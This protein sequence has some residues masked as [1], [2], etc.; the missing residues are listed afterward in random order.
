MIISMYDSPPAQ[1]RCRFTLG[2]DT[3]VVRSRLLAAAVAAVALTVPLAAGC[4]AHSVGTTG[5]SSD[6]ISTAKPL[7]LTALIAHP[8]PAVVTYPVGTA[9]P[10]QPSSSASPS[11]IPAGVASL[12]DIEAALEKTLP[13]GQAVGGFAAL[14]VH[15][16]L[17]A[18][19]TI[20]ATGRGDASWLCS[21]TPGEHLTKLA[22]P[23]LLS[24]DQGLHKLDIREEIEVSVPQLYG[25]PSPCGSTHWFGPGVVPGAQHWSVVNGRREGSSLEI[26]YTGDW[27]YALV[28]AHGLPTPVTV[29]SRVGYELTRPTGRAWLLDGW[30]YASN[31]IT[32]MWSPTAPVP[33]G[34]LPAT[35]APVTGDPAAL[36]ALRSAVATWRSQRGLTGTVVLASSAQPATGSTA[37]PYSS[38]STEATQISPQAGYAQQHTTEYIYNGK[39][40]QGVGSYPQ[41]M[42][43]TSGRVDLTRVESPQKITAIPGA[44][45]AAHPRW[46]RFRNDVAGDYLG[47]ADTNP[48]LPITMLDHAAAAVPV[49]C[50]AGLPGKRCITAAVPATPTSGPGPGDVTYSQ[51]ELTALLWSQAGS[52]STYRLV[53]AS[54]D[55]GLGVAA[56]TYTSRL[57]EY[58]G[59]SETDTTTTSFKAGPAPTPI[60][61]PAASEI[62]DQDQILSAG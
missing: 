45:G 47:T 18:A 3:F 42:I 50:P 20:V 35:A 62:L 34:Y 32:S 58:G 22:T 38:T 41:E 15:N 10:P 44:A 37:K 27:S 13:T 60:P 26:D 61:E 11:S 40:Q 30:R 31:F 59:A 53:T 2:R 6:K 5:Q 56:A 39:A 49:A 7:A 51:P 29:R 57:Y 25:S 55:N 46:V 23:S 52:G 48:F 28:D 19:A 21:P 12:T 4:S 33:A 36:A 54:L 8:A 17:L 43:F 24:S 9:T 16:A 1:E 14:D